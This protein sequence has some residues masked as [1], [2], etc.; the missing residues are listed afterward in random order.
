MIIEAEVVLEE[1]HIPVQNN[2]M[3]EKGVTSL[4]PSGPQILID[5]EGEVQVTDLNREQV[6]AL[7]H[8]LT[9]WRGDGPLRNR[10]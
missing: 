4:V 5:W 10:G 7:L 6:S 3:W 1:K 8:P 2:L 9:R